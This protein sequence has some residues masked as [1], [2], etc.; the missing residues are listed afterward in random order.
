MF[1]VCSGYRLQTE[2]TVRPHLRSR[3]PLAFS[4]FAFGIGQ[5]IRHGCQ[6]L[7]SLFRALGHLPV[8]LLG[9]FPGS[10]VLTTLDCL[11]WVGRGMDMVSLL[12]LA[13]VVNI[14]FLL[15]SSISLIIQTELLRSFLMAL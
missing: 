10:L 12:V 4:G 14:S 9:S 6:F 2:K 15:L 3:R 11:T 1:E 7:H 8:V 13:R 5:E